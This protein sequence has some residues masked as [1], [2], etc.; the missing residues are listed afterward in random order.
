MA[1]LVTPEGAARSRL[2]VPPAQLI[3]EDR[4]L[5][6]LVARHGRARPALSEAITRWAETHGEALRP[7]SGPP[8]S[9][10]TPGAR[11]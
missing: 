3:D 1:V 8:P 4:A 11:L 2:L 9:P 6:Q 7:A 10:A 5:F